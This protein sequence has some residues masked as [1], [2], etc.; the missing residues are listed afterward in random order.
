MTKW[1]GLQVKYQPV[2]CLAGQE[3]RKSKNHM[4]TFTILS[5]LLDPKL[6]VL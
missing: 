3:L 1:S 4:Q 5:A 2:I 6:N